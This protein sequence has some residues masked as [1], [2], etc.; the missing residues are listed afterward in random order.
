MTDTSWQLAHRKVICDF[1]SFLNKESDQFVLK[2]GTALY[3]C[4][5]L[6]RFSE[7]IDLDSTKRDIKE[8]VRRF[9]STYG[10]EATVTKDT[11][12]VK[13][14]MIDYGQEEHRLKIEVSYRQIAINPEDVK[15]VNSVRVYSIDRLAQLKASAYQ[16]RD[17]IRDLYDLSFICLEHFDELSEQ[18][19]NVVRD[20]LMNKGLDQLDY[21][22][23]TQEDPLI[24][25]DKL[26]INFLTMHE[27]LG[28]LFDKNDD[29]IQ[30]TK[31]EKVIKCARSR[32]R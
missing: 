31:P 20:A 11:N 15:T 4:Y 8:C 24:D 5:G 28:L 6:D 29:L 9:C 22:L 10:Y 12:L 32:S 26:L 19:K 30:E 14:C 21:L 3:V 13:R 27:K 25:N 17:K 1:L 23:H 2:G 7:D 16:N 18:T